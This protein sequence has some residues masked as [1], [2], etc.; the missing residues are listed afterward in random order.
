MPFKIFALKKLK[1]SKTVLKLI[2]IQL[3]IIIILFDTCHGYLF[4]GW[5]F[6]RHR[7]PKQDNSFYIYAVGASTMRGFPFPDRY[8]IAN[9]VKRSFGGSLDGKE[10]KIIRNG[11][12][13]GNLTSQYFILFWE[14]ALR[15]P[16]NG[17]VLIYSGINEHNCDDGMGEKT[18]PLWN[19]LYKSLTFSAVN[20]FIG[21]KIMPADST[22]MFISSK[23]I[24]DFYSNSYKKYNFF[25]D[26]IVRLAKKNN[27]PVVIS[28]LTANKCGYKT[29]PEFFIPMEK[30][31][32]T[33]KT[34]LSIRDNMKDPKKASDVLADIKKLKK[35]YKAL[36]E[37]GELHPFLSQDE[38]IFTKYLETEEAFMDKDYSKAENYITDLIK[39]VHTLYDPIA[40]QQ[41]YHNMLLRLYYFK[42]EILA[43][44]NKN[45][46][47]L[48]YAQ[49]AVPVYGATCFP[50]P[51]MNE[52]IRNIAKK[53]DIAKIESEKLLLEHSSKGLLDYELFCDG[54]HFSKKGLLIMGM[55][56]AKKASV[57]LNKELKHK[58]LTIYD[59]DTIEEKMRE[60]LTNTTFFIGYGTLNK[61]NFQK[62]FMSLDQLETLVKSNQIKQ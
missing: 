19:L 7:L 8:N 24:L 53:H 62:L 32:D 48:N 20:T 35:R 38:Y 14:L 3:A 29:F 23:T 5:R 44:L 27:L 57:L 17:I 50:R 56:F 47:A 26:K 6:L 18:F 11:E 46:E 49:K 52:V 59:T 13:G 9:T 25:L 43:A 21:Q 45:K 37:Q 34:L 31:Q 15:P 10:I 36:E 55:E 58:S 40:K 2:F 28:T 39:H 4:S 41:L 33:H 1:Q 42:A 61:K 16:K 30:H 22:K 51:A 54:H 60:A 12:L